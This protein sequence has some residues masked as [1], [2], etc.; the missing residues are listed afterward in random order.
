LGGISHGKKRYKPEGKKK[1]L[2]KSTQNNVKSFSRPKNGVYKIVKKEKTRKEMGLG[3]I[4]ERKKNSSQ[5]P[6]RK[7]AQGT[8]WGKGQKK[9]VNLSI[10]T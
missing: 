8:S 10:R 2:A 1:S 9:G 3:R 7:S 5:G 4:A 6:Y